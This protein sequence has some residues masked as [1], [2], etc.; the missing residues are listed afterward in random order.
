MK[1]I[2]V[3]GKKVL[4]EKLM[5]GKNIHI[6]FNTCGSDNCSCR[7]GFRH[8][9]YYYIR[10]KKDGRYKDVY[11]KPPKLENIPFKYQIVDSDITAEINDIKEIPDIFSD[12]S[13]FEIAMQVK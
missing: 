4:E 11:V 5:R 1:V 7:L 9:P 3:S 2:I 6:K 10:K 13:V 8:G 12:C